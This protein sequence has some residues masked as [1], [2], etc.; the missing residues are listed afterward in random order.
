VAEQQTPSKELAAILEDIPAVDIDTAGS[1]GKKLMAGGPA[2]IE[3]LIGMVGQYFGDPAGAMAKYAMHGA[4]LH[5]GRPGGD[6]GRKMVAEVLAGQLAKEHSVDMKAFIIRQLQFCGRSDE[7]PS[8]AKFLS[9][10]QLCEPATQALLAIGGATAAAALRGALAG[11][12]GKHRV[13]L[14][15]AVGRLRDKGSVPSARKLARDENR[16]V[17]IAAL[18][19]LGNIGDAESSSVLLEAVGG[20]DSYERTQAVDACLLLARR[21]GEQGDTAN[22]AKTCRA[23]STARNYD[24][25]AALAVLAETCGT[26]AVG[27]V[28]AAM[29]SKDVKVRHPAA[30]TAVKL[31]GAIAKKHSAEAGKLLKKALKATKDRV[32]IQDAEMLLAGS[33][34]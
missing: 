29:D 31:A 4:A 17:R 11:A 22:A 20:K 9:D 28:M 12:E 10:K 34:K 24:R 15:N 25:C 16:D 26:D 3:E 19:A 8:M 27:D 5:A 23:L 1:V 14:L 2:V 13:T 7:T 33:G 32:V 30:R 21:L 18:Y 6:K